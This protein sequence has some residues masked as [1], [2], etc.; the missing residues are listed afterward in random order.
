MNAC[1]GDYSATIELYLDKEL[2]GPDLEEFRAH[3]EECEACRAEFAAAEELSRLLH[4]SRPLYS[5]P[6][7]LRDRVLQITPEPLPSSSY[8]PPRLRKRFLKF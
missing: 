6:D 8:A 2:S 4:R 7:A 3:L 1:G 5:A